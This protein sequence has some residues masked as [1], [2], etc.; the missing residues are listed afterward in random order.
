MRHDPETLN[1][2]PDMISNLDMKLFPDEE[3]VGPGQ[4]VYS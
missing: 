2:L 4:E 3:S 1:C